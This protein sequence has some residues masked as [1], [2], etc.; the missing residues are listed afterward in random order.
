MIQFKDLIQGCV[1]THKKDQV[2]YA[3]IAEAQHPIAMVVACS[4]SRVDPALIMRCQPGDIFVLRHVANIVPPY[5]KNDHMHTGIGAALKYGVDHLHIQH[6]IVMGHSCCGGIKAAL[7]GLNSLIREEYISTWL[8]QVR[9]IAEQ[10]KRECK[11]VVFEKQAQHCEQKNVLVSID[12]LMTY[13]WIKTAV[14]QQQLFLHAWYFDIQNALVLSYN[15][16]TK[17]FQS[18]E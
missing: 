5:D 2:K 18:V 12:H 7:H 14:D 9:P 16:N 1:T 6:L 10:V 3:A 13:P 15:M 11:D 4:D 8:D 17:S